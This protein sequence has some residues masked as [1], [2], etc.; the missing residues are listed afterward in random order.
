MKVMKCA[1]CGEAVTVPVCRSCG[2]E[3]VAAAPDPAAERAAT[4]R[5]Q[6][7][8][9]LDQTL[10]DHDQTASDADQSSSDR[11]QTASDRDGR[12]A[13]EDQEA[14]DED[15]IAG[16]DAATHARTTRARREA[17]IARG[18]SSTMRDDTG[19][20]RRQTANARDRAAA[21]RDRGAQRRDALASMRDLTDVGNASRDD[22]AL[23][24]ERD[25]VRAADDRIKAA[26]DRARAADDRQAAARERENASRAAT[27]AAGALTLAATDELTG[28]RT[29]KTGLDDLSHELSRAHRTSGKLVLA[30]LDIDGLKQINDNHGHP[31]G[32]ALL[33]L[34][35]ETLHAQL[36]P[37]DVIVRY[38]GDEF[39]CAMPNFTTAEAR[40][41]LESI[42]AALK[43]GNEQ[44]SIT[45]G[46]SQATPADSL[47]TLIARADD[48]LLESRRVS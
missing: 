10:S 5:D 36:R 38:G 8:S 22:L 15:L 1:A 33:R 48:D 21:L 42:A 11:D 4:D 34:V 24:G 6:S 45:F 30:F 13:S 43:V 27:D 18:D 25:R 14:A 41:R 19:E 23:R 28:A 31:A 40:A 2:S 35:G 44:H 16:S 46:L 26:D 32:D 20:E 3:L 7:A 9:D 47:E 37:Y 39:I 12:S 17:A 29:R